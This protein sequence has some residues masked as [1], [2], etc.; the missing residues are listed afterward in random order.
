M[1]VAVVAHGDGVAVAEMVGDLNLL[2]ASDVRARLAAAVNDGHSRLVV[3]LTQVG[4]ID[5]SGLGALISGLKSAR[6][7]GGDLRI[8]CP[9]EQARVVLKLTTLDRVLRPYDSVE[10][11]LENF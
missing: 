6:Q 7:A 1:D 11:A 3:D 8:A 10:D 2:C 5:S 9:G 4:F